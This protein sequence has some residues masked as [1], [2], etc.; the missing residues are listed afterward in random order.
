MQIHRLQLLLGRPQAIIDQVNAETDVEL[1][2]AKRRYESAILEVSQQHE[3]VMDE[4]HALAN[5]A[6]CLA[7]QSVCLKN[8]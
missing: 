4:A 7:C 6:H 5:R 8:A 1:A 2:E 3:T